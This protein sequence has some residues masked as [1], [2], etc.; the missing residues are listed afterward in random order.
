[1]NE[2]LCLWAL[3]V[4]DPVPLIERL[5]PNGNPI[6]QFDRVHMTNPSGAKDQTKVVISAPRKSQP[7]RDLKRGTNDSQVTS[8]APFRRAA[9]P[10]VSV[11]EL[12]AKPRYSCQ[13]FVSI[14]CYRKLSLR[15]RARTG[16]HA[17]IK[18][19]SKKEARLFI[20]IK[21]LTPSSPQQR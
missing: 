13:I 4:F 14:C 1:M 5:N 7:A 17:K 19:R 12:L 2:S 9:Y 10:F 18:L 15:S 16:A 6:R 20:R 11:T 21:F 3:N 8:S